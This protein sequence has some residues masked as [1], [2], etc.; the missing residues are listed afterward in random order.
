MGSHATEKASVSE[1]IMLFRQSGILQ[2]FN[3]FTSSKSNREI[4]LKIYKIVNK[5]DIKK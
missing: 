4:I 2:N 3:I 5:L 1:R